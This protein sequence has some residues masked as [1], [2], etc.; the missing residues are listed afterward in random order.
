MELCNNYINYIR[1]KKYETTSLYSCFVSY[2]I[3]E[4]GEVF[5]FIL[6]DTEDCIQIG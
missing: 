3:Q 2:N 1:N 4:F 6:T 5:F